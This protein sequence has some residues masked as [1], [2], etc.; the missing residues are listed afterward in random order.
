MIPTTV[1]TVFTVSLMLGVKEG[2]TVETVIES[3]VRLSALPIVALRA[4]AHG[5]SYASEELSEWME[6]KSGIIDAFFKWSPSE[7]E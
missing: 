2:M 5:Y 7:E 3:L 1:G 6:T 4:Y